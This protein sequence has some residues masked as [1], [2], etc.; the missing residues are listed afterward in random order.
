[1]KGITSGARPTVSVA[2]TRPTAPAYPTLLSRA[3]YVDGML[4]SQQLTVALAAAALLTGCGG[5]AA[6]PSSPDQQ[7]FLQILQEGR[8]QYNDAPNEIKM[9][10]AEAARDEALCEPKLA[11]PQGWTGRIENLST[12]FGGLELTIGLDG[13]V[14][15]LSGNIPEEDPVFA[16]ATGLKEGDTV[17][18]D[19]NFELRDNCVDPIALFQVNR[20]SQPNFNIALTSVGAP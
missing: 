17:T 18:F 19:G 10:E 11:N 14:D 16:M 4:R 1:M 12:G 15:L 7:L 2:G 5:G 6:A 13:D 3:V 9:D 20:M 8:E